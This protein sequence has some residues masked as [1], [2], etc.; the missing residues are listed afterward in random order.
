MA[1]I[2]LRGK[3]SKSFKVDVFSQSSPVLKHDF[4]SGAKGLPVTHAYKHM[5]GYT[6]ATGDPTLEV[7][8]R[9]KLT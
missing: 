3:G 5:G 8:N 2:A 1:T 6:T 9:I 4:K 7:A